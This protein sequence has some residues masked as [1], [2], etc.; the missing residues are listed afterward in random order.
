MARDAN[1]RVMV[2]AITEA[3]EEALDDVGDEMVSLQAEGHAAAEGL[4]AASGEM[5]Q[6]TR[7]AVALQSAIDEVGDEALSTAAQAEILQHA[8]D[9]VSEEAREAALSSGAASGSFSALSVSSSGAAISVGTLSTAFT[10]SLIP[11]ILTASTVLA[12]LVVTLGA[13]AAAAAALAGAF[14]LIIGSGILAFGKQ[15]ADQQQDELDRTNRLINHYESLQQTQGQLTSQE[16]D[17][18][19]Q[20]R[21]KK[22]ELEDQTSIMGALGGAM[23]DLSDELVPLIVAFGDEFVPLIEEGLDAIPDVVEEMLNAVGGTDEFKTALRDFGALAADILPALTG[24]MFDLARAALPIMR[25]LVDFLLRNGEDALDAMQES[26]TELAP[27][28]YD[29]LDALVDL[30]P[31]LL[32]FG[33]TVGET[34]IPA[35]TGLVDAIDGLLEWFNDLDPATQDILVKILLLAPAIVW[36]SG[37]LSG[38]I[39]LFVGSKGIIALVKGLSAS[40]ATGGALSTA[41]LYG[42][43]VTAGIGLGILGTRALWATGALQDVREEGEKLR[44]E[45][46][47]EESDDLLNM[48]NIASFG[49]FETISK[50]GAVAR[51]IAIPGKTVEGQMRK[52]D[53]VFRN[54]RRNSMGIPEGEAMR[55]ATRGPTNPTARGNQVNNTNV[56]IDVA[57]DLESDPYTFSR[58][59]ADQVTREQRTNN[60]T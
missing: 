22:K 49:Q 58:D 5:S 42:A 40:L 13:V 46:G 7:M 23:S 12:P 28:F 52:V 19:Q 39:K 47:G 51:G 21:Q 36:L 30:A 3:A 57:G 45:L 2:S 10:L 1:V 35:I 44:Q 32:E 4:D 55:S 43:A 26:V 54:A 18:L 48:L 14:G 24:L 50:A 31:D 8:L 60:G 59:V 6:A 25:E 17:R 33:T 15:R 29:L 27:E 34:L 20:L 16:E 38:L 53:N 9:S 37:K 11:A 41:T 56:S